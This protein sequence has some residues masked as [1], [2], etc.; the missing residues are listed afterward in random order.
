M[1][2]NVRGVATIAKPMVPPKSR[3]AEREGTKSKPRRDDMTGSEKEKSGD[4]EFR[5]QTRENPKAFFELQNHLINHHDRLQRIEDHLGIKK[6]SPGMKAE[7]QAQMG[8]HERGQRGDVPGR[9]EEKKGTPAYGRK[10][11]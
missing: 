2:R 7:D 5:Q 3:E 8:G 11:H 9:V 6:P 4:P 1:T 10:R